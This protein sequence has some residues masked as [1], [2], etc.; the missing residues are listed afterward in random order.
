MSEQR[1]KIAIIGTGYVGLV[2]GTCFAEDGYQVTCV[3]SD[4]RKIR[5]LK[6]GGMPIYE[7]GL[8]ELVQKMPRPAGSPS[9]PAHPKALPSPI[10]FSSPSP[11]LRCPTAPSI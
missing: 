9:L 4:D 5:L 10:S 7:P 3:D 2:T 8:K 11:P 1:M 6:Q